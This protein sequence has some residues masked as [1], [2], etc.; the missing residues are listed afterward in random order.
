MP[1]S[2]NV[3]FNYFLKYRNFIFNGDFKSCTRS[4]PIRRITNLTHI[5]W[6]GNDMISLI[7]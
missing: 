2:C 4:I 7:R 5:F 1:L 3:R 6:K